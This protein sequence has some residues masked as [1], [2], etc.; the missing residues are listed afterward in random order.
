MIPK[1]YITF[2]WDY[3]FTGAYIPNARIQKRKIA[4]CRVFD[5]VRKKCSKLDT[6]TNQGPKN[7]KRDLNE[8]D[9]AGELRPLLQ[10]TV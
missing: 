5:S 2:S 1:K 9:S 8:K 7:Q 4:T 3:P 10:H 6:V